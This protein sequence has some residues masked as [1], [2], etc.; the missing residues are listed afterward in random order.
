M[1]PQHLHAKK[2]KQI[3]SKSRND[4]HRLQPQTKPWIRY[5]NTQLI[6]LKSLLFLRYWAKMPAAPHNT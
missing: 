5:C 4:P 3:N 6:C 1:S 2:Y